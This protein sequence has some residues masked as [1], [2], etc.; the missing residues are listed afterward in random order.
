MIASITVIASSGAMK[1][2]MSC[3]MCGSVDKS[4]ADH[5][6]VTQVLLVF[7]LDAV[8]RQVIDF[9]LSACAMAKDADFELARQIGVFGRRGEVVVGLGKE[10][11]SGR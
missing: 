8:K 4:A 5:H 6:A 2:P 10:N 11:R 7:A 1:T 3:A 9:A